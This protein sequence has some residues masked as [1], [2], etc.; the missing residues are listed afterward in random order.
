MIIKLFKPIAVSFLMLFFTL[1]LCAST[2]TV[3]GPTYGYSGVNIFYNGVKEYNPGMFPINHNGYDTWGFCVDLDY[4]VASGEN[5][6]DGEIEIAANYLYVEWL[7]GTYANDL[8]AEALANEN[9]DAKATALQ[10][11]IWEVRYDTTWDYDYDK[12]NGIDDYIDPSNPPNGT[13]FFYYD[14]GL[15][16]TSTDPEVNNFYDDYIKALTN[17][18]KDQS[19]NSFVSSGDY[20]V[21]D[22]SQQGNKTQDII[23]NVV[24]EPTTVLLLGFGLLGLCAVG[25]KKA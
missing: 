15:I 21:F 4:Q 14:R 6:I 5:I 23:V 19:W 10:L 12:T 17:A 20:L 2:L 24:P 1:P 3:N 16:K 8:Y 22:L 25:R 7:V 18:V 11:A 9:I 13:G